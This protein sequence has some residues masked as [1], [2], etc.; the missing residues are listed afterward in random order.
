VNERK[1]HVY[2]EQIYA[3]SF[4]SQILQIHNTLLLNFELSLIADRFLPKKINSAKL[5]LKFLK[6]ILFD[7]VK[8][9]NHFFNSYFEKA[10]KVLEKQ[11]L[12]EVSKIT[13]AELT[14]FHKMLIYKAPIAIFAYGIFNPYKI[15][16]QVYHIFKT[17]RKN[18]LNI[19]DLTNNQDRVFTDTPEESIEDNPFDMFLSF[20]KHKIK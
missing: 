6:D 16:R 17:K 15:T 8:Q 11:N 4:N 20:L 12:P 5:G 1:I 10:K 2:L 18:I 13:N 19:P 14:D 7:P 9:N 3:H